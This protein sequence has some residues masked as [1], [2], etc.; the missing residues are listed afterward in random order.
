M[1]YV[2]ATYSGHLSAQAQYS[3]SCQN[4]RYNS[5]LDTWTLLRLTAYKF[6]TLIFVRC[7][8]RSKLYY[9]RQFVGQ[10][11]LVSGTHQGPAN[12]FSNSLFDYFLLL[13]WQFRV[14]WCGAPSLT[15]SQ[16]CTFQFLQVIAS[17]AFLRSESHGTHKLSLSVFLRL[18]Q[19]GGPGSYVYFLQEQGTPI[20][21]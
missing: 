18:P 11:V 17:A 13:F 21:R 10:S 3:R 15:R 2:Y 5:N 7:L 1:F 4:L 19:P 20:T 12:N 6:K 16:V 8:S 14:C 9:K